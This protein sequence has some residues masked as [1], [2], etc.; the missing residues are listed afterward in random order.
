MKKVERSGFIRRRMRHTAFVLAVLLVMVGV[1]LWQI[2]PKSLFG[3]RG[4]ERGPLVPT[5]CPDTLA[6]HA[7]KRMQPKTASP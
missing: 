5:A 2:Q 1:L 4:V 6:C 7:L 3:G